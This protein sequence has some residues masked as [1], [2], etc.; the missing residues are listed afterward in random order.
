[1]IR[2]SG[3]VCILAL[4]ACGPEPTVRLVV[5]DDAMGL[6]HGDPVR[7]A[8]VDVG[9][10]SS[11]E[12]RS[13]QAEI[14]FTVR[15]DIDLVTED[16]CGIVEARG[17]V[18]DAMLVLRPTDVEPFPDERAIT[19]CAPEPALGD[20]TGPM[21]SAASSMAEFM[22]AAAHGDGTLAR[23]ANDE[24][25]ADALLLFLERQEG[26]GAPCPEA[27]APAAVEP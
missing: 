10:V 27:T 8:G 21:V 16:T 11:V 2:A 17:L 3:F 25:L 5:V 19:A 15:P 23:L 12:L 14:R 24:E 20:A 18:G 6:H 4:S 26:E 13:G 1:M 22:D 9:R 7:C